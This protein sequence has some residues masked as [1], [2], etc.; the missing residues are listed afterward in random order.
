MRIPTKMRA[1]LFLGLIISILLVS[2]HVISLPLSLALEPGDASRAGIPRT[3]GKV[4]YVSPLGNDAWSGKLAE[5]NRA[6]TDGPFATLTR[7]RDAIRAMPA[8]QPLRK[9]VTVYV[10]GG[11]YTLNATLVFLPEDSGT[12]VPHHLR[13]LSGRKTG[14]ERRPH[15]H[16][17][18]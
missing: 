18:E 17:M 2:R 1:G 3:K 4:F 7:A 8:R 16:G 13:R 9:P 11:V 12:P 14:S 6:G 15:D 5:P 10:R